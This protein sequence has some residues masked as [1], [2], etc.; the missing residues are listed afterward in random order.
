[1]GSKRPV[2]Y[3]IVGPN[4]EPL[5]DALAAEMQDTQC[6]WQ[7]INEIQEKNRSLI[8]T[9]GLVKVYEPKDTVQDSFQGTA[10]RTNVPLKGLGTEWEKPLI[11]RLL[12]NPTQQP[13]TSQTT[14]GTT[15]TQV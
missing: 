8:T 2:F 7:F 1:M 3:Q 13:A 6:M 15:Y 4:G 10:L 11:I 12:P 5:T 14:V 9:V